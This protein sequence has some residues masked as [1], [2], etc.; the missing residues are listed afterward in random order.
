MDR[1]SNVRMNEGKKLSSRAQVSK[2]K[3][4]Q[5]VNETPAF[6]SGCISRSAVGGRRSAVGGRSAGG[7]SAGDSRGEGATGRDK[8]STICVFISSFQFLVHSPL[9]TTTAVWLPTGF[10]TV[11]ATMTTC[12]STAMSC[13]LRRSRRRSGR[14]SSLGTPRLGRSLVRSFARSLVRSSARPLVRFSRCQRGG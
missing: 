6:L 3:I 2:L 5:Y 10:S 9:Q 13:C 11:N 4:G 12:T 8:F 14:L 1:C 7:R